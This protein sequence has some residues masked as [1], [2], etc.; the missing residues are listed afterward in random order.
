MARPLLRRPH[1]IWGPQ[2]ND[3]TLQ[4]RK[5]DISQIILAGMSAN[6]CVESH[7]REFLELGLKSRLYGTQ[8]LPHGYPKGMD[9][10]RL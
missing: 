2:T 9:I 5:K 1:K 6:L 10:R 3:L 8:P 4:L 7:L